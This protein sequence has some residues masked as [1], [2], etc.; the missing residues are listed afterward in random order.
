LDVDSL[1]L[2]FDVELWERA[3]GICGMLD[4]WFVLFLLWR[5]LSVGKKGAVREIFIWIGIFLGG[6]F[7]WKL[8]TEVA[9]EIVKYHFSAAKFFL[10]VSATAIV[11]LIFTVVFLRK[12]GK[13][14]SEKLQ[15]VPFFSFF[16][17]LLGVC[18]G[19]LEGYLFLFYMTLSIGLASPENPFLK[20]S[21]L[22][23]LA[24]PAGDV[25]VDFLEKKFSLPKEKEKWERAKEILKRNEEFLKREKLKAI[26]VR[27]RHCFHALGAA[28]QSL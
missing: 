7:G 4:Y 11:T 2:W 19:I 26:L 8:A 24:I 16:N 13:T 15:K 27:Q 14:L 3:F 12:I 17:T 23:W 10:I 9:H 18:L 25:A 1:F 20:G 21:F 6:F 5:I 22:G 28:L